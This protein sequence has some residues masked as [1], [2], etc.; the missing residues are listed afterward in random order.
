M[1]TRTRESEQILVG[2]GGD[3]SDR[4]APQSSARDSGFGGRDGRLTGG[5]RQAV[6]TSTSSAGW[7]AQSWAGTGCNVSEVGRNR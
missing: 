3:K 5:T 4:W 1:P 6:S 7:V 2:F